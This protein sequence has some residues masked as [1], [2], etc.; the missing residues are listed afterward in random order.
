VHAEI[1]DKTNALYDEAVRRL[2]VKT[3]KTEAA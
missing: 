3:M 1:G 2:K